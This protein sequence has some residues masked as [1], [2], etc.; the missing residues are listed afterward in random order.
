MVWLSWA[1][2]MNYSSKAPR[3]IMTGIG[4][5]QRKAMEIILMLLA[6]LVLYYCRPPK[7]KEFLFLIQVIQRARFRVK[8]EKGFVRRG[9]AVT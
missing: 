9:A 4:S 1:R 5:R 8:R 2:W 7:T 6:A 3:E